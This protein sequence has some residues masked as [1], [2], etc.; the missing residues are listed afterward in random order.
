MDFK[1]IPEPDK[2]GICA[3]QD[4]LAPTL[5]VELIIHILDDVA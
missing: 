4:I 1:L 3:A 5:P 2:S